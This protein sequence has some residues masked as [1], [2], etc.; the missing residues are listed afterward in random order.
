[1]DAG[2]S[3]HQ[4]KVSDLSRGGVHLIVA[5][6]R[7]VG[8]RGAI[9]FRV[10]DEE[11]LLCGVVVKRSGPRNGIFTSLRCQFSEPPSR[12]LSAIIVEGRTMRLRDDRSAA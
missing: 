10:N 11:G 4:V 1:M 9:L 12:L 7:N 8:D 6:S 5:G 2:L 3:I